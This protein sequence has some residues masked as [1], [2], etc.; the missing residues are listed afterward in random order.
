MRTLVALVMMIC[1]TGAAAETENWMQETLVSVVPPRSDASPA[2]EPLDIDFVSHRS[3]PAPLP[4]VEVDRANLWEFEE[5]HGYDLSVTEPHLA[6]PFAAQ[7][8]AAQSANGDG[9]TDLDALGEAMANPLSYLW[10]LFT[11]ND[12]IWQDGDVLDALGEDQQTQNTFLLQ[13][14]VSLQITERWKTIIRPVIPIHSF[15]TVDNLDI[16][17][18]NTGPTVGVNF[19]RESGLGDIVLWTAFSKQYTPPFVWGFGPTVML[20]TASDDFLGT[21]K[22]SAG[23]MLLAMGITEK[24]IVGGVLQHWWSFSGSDKITVRTN[25]G[26]VRVERPDVN[27][28]DFQPILRYRLDAKTNIGAAPNWRYNHETSKLSLPIGIGFD[29]LVMLGKLPAK[30]GLEAY[31]YVEKDDDYGPDWQLRFLFVPVVPAP[32]WSR[33]PIF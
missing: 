25:A 13:P 19:D 22:N 11:Q 33:N 14:V 2:L 6:L 4:P 17:T 8:A 28:T 7:A 1:G 5:L 26:P 32:A 18:G 29:T 30:I 20:D 23:P 3:L 24:W 16:S 15:E 10:L 31:Y 9:G 21:G 12:T 27:L